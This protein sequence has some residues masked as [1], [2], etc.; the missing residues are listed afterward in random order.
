[1]RMVGIPL[2]LWI[3]C[4]V[5]LRGDLSQAHPLS[6]VTSQPTGN[7]TEPATSTFPSSKQTGPLPTVT[8]VS[9]ANNL[10]ASSPA[11]TTQVTTPGS[12]P[13]PSNHGPHQGHRQAATPTPE[14]QSPLDASQTILGRSLSSTTTTAALVPT[15]AEPRVSQP[16]PTEKSVLTVAAFGVISFIVILVVVVI[17]LVSVVSLRFRCNRNKESENAQKP[18]ISGV[19]ESCSPDNGEKERITLISMKNIN[20]NNSKGCSMA[21][22]VL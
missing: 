20:M 15:E 3:F 11:P 9:A 13:G 6:T 10:S 18:G 17:V 1:M 7:T 14:N 5:L 8:S 21:E 19:S 12:R 22:K 16:S 4:H 2:G